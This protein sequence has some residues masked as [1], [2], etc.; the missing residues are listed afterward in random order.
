M[1]ESRI[2]GMK[3]KT[4]NIVLLL[5]AGLPLA[6]FGPCAWGEYYSPS[7]SVA[8]TIGT[9]SIGSDS[10]QDCDSIRIKWW[11]AE[12]GWS[13][14][15]TK[16]LTSS[17]EPGFYG[18]SVK[19]SDASD[20]TGN[21]VANAV[22]Y[23]FDGSY[24]DI[25]TWSWTVVETFDSLANAVKDANKTNF[26]ADLSNLLQKAD[27]SLYM[28]TDWENVKNQNAE[29]DLASTSIGHVDTADTVIETVSA[30]CDTESIGRSAWDEDVVPRAERRIQYV[31]SVG[32]EMSASVDTAEIKIM[33]DNNQ[34]GASW[35]WNYSVRTLTSAAGSGAN[36]VVIRC[37]ASSDSS[38]VAFAQIQV[39]DSTESSTIGLLT[40]D[41]QGRG[42]FA[43]D[44]GIYCVRLY[45]PGWQFIVP[46]TLQVDED[47]DTTYY[48][49]A[50][51]PSSPPE[52]SLCRVYGWVYDINDQPMVG[53][54]VEASIKTIPLR[55]ENL[56]ISPYYKTTVTDDEGFW[57][58]DL[59]PTPSL[60]PSD[61]RY[62][63]HIFSPSGTILR[64]EVE[65]PN[66][67]SWE[68][69]W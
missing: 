16:K 30:S 34:W 55:Y 13:Y 25:K 63:F 29:V 58:L 64:L 46:E 8:L 1:R 66:L 53:A 7:D 4:P 19:A 26:R 10:I 51:D 45:K 11:W 42:F 65:V 48:G 52:A 68:L 38:V 36:S 44:Q 31:D 56:L 15:G 41:S 9:V 67:T 61:T 62:V 33:N 59:Y 20:H 35:V 37:K 12:G 39:L 18:T 60:S 50:F 40:S 3:L 47:E 49:E 21:Y 5:L 2:H 69:Q 17:V 6:I 23:K 14:V 43:M 54:K 57:Y 28:R 27:S 22:A 32:E 24:T